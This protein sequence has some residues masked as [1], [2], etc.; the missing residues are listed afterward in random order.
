M[1]P[2]VVALFLFAATLAAAAPTLADQTFWTLTAKPSLAPAPSPW[3]VTINAEYLTYACRYRGR[4]TSCF[5]ERPVAYGVQ[6]R[7]YVGQPPRPPY[8]PPPSRIVHPQRPPVAPLPPVRTAPPVP[9][10]T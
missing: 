8:P 4:H 5:C 6:P 9:T 7:C 3:P 1:K 10:H 2:F